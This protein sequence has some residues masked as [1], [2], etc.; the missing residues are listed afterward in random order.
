MV[1]HK[2][3]ITTRGPRDVTDSHHYRIP[4]PSVCPAGAYILALFVAPASAAPCNLGSLNMTMWQRASDFHWVMACNVS[5]HFHRENVAESSRCQLITC[6]YQVRVCGEAWQLLSRDMSVQTQ[7]P[8]P[9]QGHSMMSQIQASIFLTILTTHV[10]R[11]P[12]IFTYL[13]H[14][15]QRAT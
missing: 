7:A 2:A 14:S 6:G 10:L 4:R 15:L 12:H 11:K 9:T 5:V 13:P 1:H 8:S 3:Y